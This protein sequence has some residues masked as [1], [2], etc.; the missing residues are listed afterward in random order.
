MTASEFQTLQMI[1]CYQVM[2]IN[3]L[4]TCIA[5]DFDQMLKKDEEL[6]NKIMRQGFKRFYPKLIAEIDGREKIVN[7]IASE[8]SEFLADC[9]DRVDELVGNDLVIFE[10]AIYSEL[11]KNGVPYPEMFAKWEMLGTMLEYSVVIT[12]QRVNELK[13][14]DRT[15]EYRLGR[16]ALKAARDIHVMANRGL[17][18]VIGGKFFVDLTK[19]KRVNDCLHAFDNKLQNVDRIL[20][21]IL[22]TEKEHEN[23]V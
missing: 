18:R 5:F 23:D 4:A 15:M 17:H 12:K 13:V 22:K 14:C 16:Y 20:D 1:S 3:E 8:H 21:I 19:S 6:T 11:D 2:F 9:H 7:D 10:N